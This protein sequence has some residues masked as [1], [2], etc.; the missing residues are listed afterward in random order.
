ML[1]YAFH[2]FSQQRYE[3][4]RQD[5][6]LIKKHLHNA[7]LHDSLGKYRNASD[8]YNKAAMIYW[9]HNYFDKA[10]KY[11][12]ES[13]KRNDKLQ[14]ANA[15]AMINSNLA[16]IYADMKKYKEAL[17]YFE[18]TYSVRKSRNEK[19]GTI[20]A[21]INMSVVLTNMKKY[22]ESI[23]KVEEALDIAREMNDAKQMCSCYGMLSQAYEKSGNPE[24][25][26]Q[27]YELYK[28]FHEMVQDKR[29]KKSKKDVENALLRTKLAE[30]EAEKKEL[31][32]I[33]KNF[34]LKKTKKKLETTTTD[35][36]DAEQKKFNL[37]KELSRSELEVR[38]VKAETEKER[39]LA[40]KEIERRKRINNIIIL[41]ALS[42]VL[43][44]VIIIIAY[45]K[46]RKKNKRL[47]FQYAEIVQQREEILQQREEITQQRD[48]L[49]EAFIKIGK[50][51][52]QITSSINYAKYIQTAM[53]TKENDLNTFINES[54]VFFK[55]RDIVSG[56]FY[57]YNK[58]DGKIIIAAVDCTGHGVPGAFLSM[59]GNELL[60]KIVVN[61]KITSPADIL[62]KM[63]A[64]VRLALNQEH[65][66]NAD[67]MDM[68][69]CTIDKKNNKLSFAGAKNPLILIRDGELHF[70]RGDRSCIG[71]LVHNKK[72]KNF[73]EKDFTITNETYM[74]VFSD[75]FVDQIGG[76]DNKKLKINNFRE[77][78]FQIHK[79]PLEEQKKLV[80]ELLQ[81]WKGKRKQIDDILIIGAKI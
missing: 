2:T 80:N 77:F 58:V 5:S 43:I 17:K 49:N 11:Y 81:N 32:L 24:K 18:T 16:L 66:K 10:V 62:Y 31:K 20:S 51:N 35:L 73:T 40:Q 67:G 26:M 28:S 19:I 1:F 75:G 3:L 55:P 50:K 29:E 57:W 4:S 72:I 12:K 25:S 45:N 60:N 69:I 36:E 7:N 64:G 8:F 71:G 65:T 74:Y 46:I 14:N 48:K 79:R 15:K 23:K 27:Y 56:D 61:E 63:D 9:E 76:E 47:S 42:L 70:E 6:A 78:I 21:L 52:K 68:V 30:T 41:I 22:N 54:F 53:L 39:L 38:F 33:N 44:A 59:I 37:L 34:I 13:L